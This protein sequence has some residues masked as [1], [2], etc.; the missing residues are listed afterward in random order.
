MSVL[1]KRSPSLKFLR[2]GMTNV[3]GSATATP[4]ATTAYKLRNSSNKR[5]SLTNLNNYFQTSQEKSKATPTT[6]K[7]KA[8][9]SIK[10]VFARLQSLSNVKG[11][12]NGVADILD[13]GPANPFKRGNQSIE[14]TIE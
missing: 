1:N 11:T 13:A 7:H 8:S 3:N 14:M 9:S 5:P 12:E 4:K 6:T 10:G 2:T